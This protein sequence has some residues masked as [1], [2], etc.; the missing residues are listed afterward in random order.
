[1][2]IPLTVEEIVASPL[3][4][5]AQRV[6]RVAGVGRPCL[7]RDS[8]G[9]RAPK[10]DARELA[11]RREGGAGLLPERSGRGDET[12]HVQFRLGR[13]TRLTAEHFLPRRRAA[14][15]SAVPRA[16]RRV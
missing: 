14:A 12:A 8:R 10:R 4:T 16:G 7:R 3:S 5:I 15:R 13:V 9:V 1:M 2:T 11:D 6:P